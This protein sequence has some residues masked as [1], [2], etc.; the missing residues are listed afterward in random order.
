MST[1]STHT[2]LPTLTIRVTVVKPCDNKT[3]F[4]SIVMTKHKILIAMSQDSQPYCK[5]HG[6]GDL[7]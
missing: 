2:R 3:L 1:Y 6:F 5:L 7:R 4:Y